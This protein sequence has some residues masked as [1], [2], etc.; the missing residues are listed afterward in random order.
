MKKRILVVDDDESV[1]ESLKK[2]LEGAG[3]EVMLA[4]GALEVAVRFEPG[5]FDL[6]VLDLV[7][8]NQTG[9]DVF[10]QLTTRRP[11]VPA[12]IITGLPNQRR[13]AEL[14][15]AGALFEKPVEPA[16]LLERIAELLCEPPDRRLERLCGM[17]EDTTYVRAGQVRARGPQRVA[18]G[19]AG[20]EAFGFANKHVEPRRR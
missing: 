18:I 12:I 17:V 15:G 5:Q 9:W 20:G 7:L 6:L 1:R 8:P 2:V 4:A 14:A 13:T 19:A 16:A 11:L 3:Y 10:E